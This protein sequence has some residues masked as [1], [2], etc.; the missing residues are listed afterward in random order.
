MR[1]TKTK[2]RTFHTIN[3]AGDEIFSVNEGLPIVEALE[4]VS[5]LLSVALPVVY[6]VAENS[7]SD[8]YAAVYLVK[9]AKAVIDSVVSG[10]P[11]GGMS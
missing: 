3:P 6:G 8:A 1:K 7:D 11:I 4:E 2:H 9:M 5:T 10:M